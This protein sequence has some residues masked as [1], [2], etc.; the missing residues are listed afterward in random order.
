MP[1]PT[2]NDI[3]QLRR[4]I[5]GYQLT[6]AIYVVAKLK[7]AD[8]L[9]GGP[10]SADDLAAETSM[11]PASLYRLMRALASQNIFEELPDR[12]FALRAM[13][14][15]LRSDVDLSLHGWAAFVGSPTHWRGWGHLLHSVET[16]KSGIEHELGMSTWK[17][18]ELHPEENAIFDA[19]MT[20][21]S[22]IANPV[23]VASCDW[24]RFR[25]I[26]DIAGGRGAMLSAILK[27]HA[28]VR[29]ILFD[30]PHVVAGAPPLLEAAG[31]AQRVEIVSG[32]F[33]E[34]VP[35]A[36]AYTMKYILHD[37]YDDDCIRILRTIRAAAAAD[38]R[39]FVIERVI[40]GPNEG[41]IAKM[42]DLNML[43]GPG[44][45]ERT[46]DEYASLFDSSGWSLATAHPAF[47]HYIME[48]KPA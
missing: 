2:A 23:I 33:F 43:V 14:E 4:M 27:K 8:L 31:V 5:N 3:D 39:L 6:Q 41:V 22:R 30:Q 16:G 36:N 12:R 13:G 1:E 15:L 26:A 24:S 32:S 20:A 29:G 35:A 7:L 37:W 25:T 44:G 38:A 28:N 17:W 47:P 40:E 48:A 34:T 45:R 11:D 42:S 18:R 19:A 9:A 46:V 10:R 21:N